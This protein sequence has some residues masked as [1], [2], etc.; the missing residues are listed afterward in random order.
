[1]PA[2]LRR[3]DAAE[4]TTGRTRFT[5]DHPRPGILHAAV[6]G[7]PHAR[8]RIVA[9]RTEAARAVPGV[10]GVFTGADFDAL[11][12]LYLGDKPPLARHEVRYHGEG[13]AAIVADDEASALRALHKIEVDYE[14]LPPVRSPREA[15]APGAP[16]LHPELATYRH[17]PAILPEP[18][19]N[20]ANRTRL[21][22]GNAEAA[23]RTAAV[24]VEGNFSFPPGDHVA[25]EPRAVEAEVRPDGRLLIRTST[26]SPFGV[27]TL[28]AQGFGLPESMIEVVVGA[29]GGGFGGKAG[30]Q[31]EP[32]AYL[33]SKGMGGRPVRLVNSREADMLT[34]PGRPG[35]EARVALAA[36]PDGTLIAAD[37]E[38]LFDSG[39]YADYAVNVSRA[40]GYACTG[41]YR[42]P[43]VKAD[44]L[45]VYTN[46]PFATAYRGFGHIELSFAV[47]RAL[48]LLADKLNM[49][50]AGL[51]LKNAV[52]AGD[53]VPSGAVLDPNTGDL[54][55]CIKLVQKR[56]AWHQGT[57][58]QIVGVDGRPK[59]VAKGIACFWKA[60]A[61]PTFTDASA[62]LIYGEDASISLATGVVELGQ[63][64]FTGLRQ[65]VAEA[66]KMDPA[67]IRAV[68]EVNTDRSPHDWP[69]DTPSAL[70]HA[71]PMS[72]SPGNMYQ[73]FTYK[74][75]LPSWARPVG[76]MNRD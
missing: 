43:H 9:I 36:E 63:G 54:P 22:K 52:L 33:L 8:A 57:R 2:S 72:T 62:I 76:F 61:I 10:R 66:L 69:V 35:L 49:D 55:G 14:I 42:I 64:T 51:R 34:S 74:L 12:G 6:I 45:C 47:E 48:D 23:F 19:T 17:I 4:K 28:L 56:L 1:M 46:H 39:G 73:S 60:P 20:I 21:R 30:I 68:T 71:E 7:S 58:T 18:G 67:K 5:D 65:I 59:I 38:F 50:P 11:I 53:T 31:L 26:Q 32:L 16:V 25:M 15:L 41:P 44:S 27:R 24:T 70:A 75:S 3:D 40:A 13:V 37:I 29:V